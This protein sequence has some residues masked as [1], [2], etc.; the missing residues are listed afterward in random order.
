MSDRI[1]YEI[2]TTGGGADGRDYNDKGGTVVAAYYD[3]GLATNHVG[4]DE[5]FRLQ[6]TVVDVS[7]VR[8]GILARLTPVERLILDP[9][10]QRR[11]RG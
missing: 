11:Q 3:K 7:E 8:K 9:D 2:V 10:S 1:V 4:K 6:P 5:R